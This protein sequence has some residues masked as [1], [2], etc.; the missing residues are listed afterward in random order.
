MT[1]LIFIIVV[2]LVTI[3]TVVTVIR[4]NLYLEK[5]RLFA[6]ELPKLTIEHKRYREKVYYN[7][8]KYISEKDFLDRMSA[9]YRLDQVPLIY[10]QRVIRETERMAQ[11][12]GLQMLRDGIIQV[13]ENQDLYTPIQIM[14]LKAI[15]YE[16]DVNQNPCGS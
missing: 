2:V 13:W 3:F 9:G 16:P 5:Q 15:V 12:I 4:T 14:H 1:V 11:Q 10:E 6:C 7:S 8:F